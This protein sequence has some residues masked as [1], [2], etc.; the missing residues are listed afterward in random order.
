MKKLIY[1]LTIYNKK[2]GK[3]NTTLYASFSSAN[4]KLNNWIKNTKNKAQDGENY[5]GVVSSATLV[6]DLR[7]GAEYDD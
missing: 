5:F 4:K 7:E 6:L 2:T 1:I 3:V